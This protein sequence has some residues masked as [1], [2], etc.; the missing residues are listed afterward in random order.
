M[1]AR[2]KESAT[3]KGGKIPQVGARGERQEGKKNEKFAS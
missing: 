1:A 3:E 2:K